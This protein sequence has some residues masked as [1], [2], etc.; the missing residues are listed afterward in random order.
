[1]EGTAGTDYDIFISRSVDDGA[2]WS[3]TTTLN[4]NTAADVGDDA[5]PHIAFDES[6]NTV[7]IWWSGDSLGGVL[8]T[9]NDVFVS[10]SSN[11]GV[12]WS[13]PE[14]LNTNAS[15]DIGNDR[16]GQIDTDGNGN[17]IVVWRSTENIGGNIGTDWDILFSHS[18]DNGLTWTAPAV[19]NTNASTDTGDDGGPK[20][21]A[22]DVGNWVVA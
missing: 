10:R 1:M 22:E 12:T 5:D 20:A 4:T 21:L 3:A 8:G 14:V 17:W 7:C 11:D 18:V 6:G 2:T 15:T 9:D 13:P 19:M 16:D